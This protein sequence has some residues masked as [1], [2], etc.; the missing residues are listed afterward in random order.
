MKTNLRHVVI[1]II[2]GEWGEDD[3]EGRGVSIIRTANFENDGKIDFNNLVTRLILKR[4]INGGK[5][6]YE[7]DTEKINEKALLN[8]DI[9]IEK[10]GGGIGSPVGRVVYFENPGNLIY[11]SNNF[12]QTL[13]INSSLAYPKYIYYYLKYLYK[14]GNVLKY[15]NQTTGIFN[16]KLEKYLKEEL[17]LPTFD[18]QYSIVTQLDTIQNTIDKRVESIDALDRLIESVYF[19]MFGDPILNTKNW[20]TQKLSSLGNWLSGG[21]PKTDIEEFYEGNVPW[22]TSGELGGVFIESSQKNISAEALENS[23]AKLIA[24]NSILIG[25]Y[26]T[27]AFKMS[28]NK[29]EC[30]CNQAILYCKLN[31]EFYTLFV[32]YTLFFSKKYYLS[33]RKGAR[34]KNLSSSF[35]K[36]IKIIFPKTQKEKDVIDKFYV[37]LEQYFLLKNRALDSLNILQTLFQAVLQKSFKSDAK[38]DEEPI[39]K[40]LIKKLSIRDLRG[41]KNRLQYLLDLFNKNEFDNVEDYSDAKEKL[42]ALILSKAIEQKIFDDEKVILQVK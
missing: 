26:D 33:K 8:G 25:L 32:Y 19:S 6:D 23:N 24:I 21:T 12:T 7:I 13:R 5:D 4:V 41:D 22:F 31:D 17:W 11:L 18:L 38:I 29:V 27:A 35:I 2:S 1:K 15:Q 30:A 10:S 39:F 40:E 34:Q 36:N 16:L 9:L 28:I 42:F 14:R 20:E 37:F 3:P